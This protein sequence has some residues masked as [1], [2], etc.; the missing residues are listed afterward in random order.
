MEGCIAVEE[1][2]RGVI[3]EL[4]ERLDGGEDGSLR[5]LPRISNGRFLT[6]EPRETRQRSVGER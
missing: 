3:A 1:F 6:H 4:A 5:T 2:R